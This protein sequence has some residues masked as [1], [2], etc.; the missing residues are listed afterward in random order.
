[1]MEIIT[2]I[3]NNFYR[4]LAR[5]NYILTMLIITVA[6][7]FLAVFFTAKLEVRGNVALLADSNRLLANAK[8]FNV[9]LVHSAPPMSDLVLN[10]YD[11]VVT[12]RGGGNFDIK[13]IKSAALVEGLRQTILHPGTPLPRTGSRGV[14]AN[15][16]GFLIMAVLLQGMMFMA[17]YSDDK[18]SGAF[19]RIATSPVRMGNYL[20]AHSVSNFLLVL[21][22]TFA[23]LAA[24]KEIFRLDIGFTY[25]QYAGFLGLL[26]LLST[27]FALFMSTVIKKADNCVTLGSSVVTLSSILAGSFFSFSASRP[28]FDAAITVLPQKSF[29][30]LVQG[31]EQGRALAGNFPQ[32]AYLLLLPIALFLLSAALTK[33]GLKNGTAA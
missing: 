19:R 20:L 31:I 3:R 8:A 27:S 28:L 25:A 24:A 13:S 32:L 11:A 29:L 12:D 4:Y 1:M 17:L 23:V 21:V 22:P 2:I 16:L 10:R 14:G 15:I 33:R 18:E 26:A 9:T 6:S 30:A 7:V 5:R